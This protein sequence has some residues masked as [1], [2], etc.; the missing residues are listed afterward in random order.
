MKQYK[1]D[2]KNIV[3]TFW[4]Y[5]TIYNIWRWAEPVLC[6]GHCRKEETLFEKIQYKYSFD[7][8]YI[9]FTQYK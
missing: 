3:A 6:V 2:N 4:S 9:S 5:V 7:I 8:K 1:M